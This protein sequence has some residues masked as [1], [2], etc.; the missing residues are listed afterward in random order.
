MKKNHW[1][2]WAIALV[3]IVLA[4]FTVRQ[5]FGTAAVVSA[6]GSPA[7]LTHTGSAVD[8][9]QCPFTAEQIRSIHAVFIDAIGH[10][11]PY[12]QDGPTGIEGGLSMLQ[13]CQAP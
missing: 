4:A 12:T 10:S 7:G 13:Y 5:V 11:L 8:P 1:F 9:N 6:S 2:N 3:L